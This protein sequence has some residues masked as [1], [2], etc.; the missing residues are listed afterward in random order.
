MNQILF[1]GIDIGATNLKYGLIDEKG[2]I[3]FRRLIPTPQSSSPD[4]LF[5]A[6]LKCSEEL[7]VEADDQGEGVNYLG[8]GSPG[9]INVKTGVVQGTCPNLPG[10]EGFHLRDRLAEKLNL[11]VYV[12]NDAN[13]ATLAETNFGAGKGYSNVICLTIGTGI[14]GGIIINGR[15]YRGVNFA[16]GEIGHI[17]VNGKYLEKVVSSPVILEKLKEQLSKKLPPAYKSIIG[18][19]LGQL[20]LKKMFVAI[21]RGDRVAPKILR[22]AGDILGTSLASLTN[23]FNPELI[24]LGGGVVEGG[25]DFVDIVKTTIMEKALPCAR[26]GLRVVPA[27]LGNNAG[28]IGAAIL[29]RTDDVE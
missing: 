15:L 28:F 29:G 17:I 4:S 19:N 21:K 22:S 2:N 23:V 26:E 24:I 16:T 5:G 1:A 6:I 20:T 11:P 14:G 18:D 12:D 10:W 3:R 27:A 7:L 25:N 8:V 9:S 13:C